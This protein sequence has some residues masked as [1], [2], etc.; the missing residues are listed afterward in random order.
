MSLRLKKF[1][2]PILS[3]FPTNRSIAG[4]V[5]IMSSGPFAPTNS[6]SEAPRPKTQG[7]AR[8]RR[9]AP[10]PKE[11]KNAAAKNVETC[12]QMRDERQ[13]RSMILQKCFFEKC[14]HLM[15]T[16]SVCSH[17]RLKKVLVQTSAKSGNVH[18]RIH[19]QTH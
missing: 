14:S 12:S 10:C 3:R 15:S 17:L 19:T 2:Y 1:F 8:R 5:S 7:F 4:L 16:N 6:S 13:I 11:L 9:S 18:A